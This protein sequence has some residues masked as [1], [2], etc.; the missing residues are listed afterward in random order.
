MNM[1]PFEL[2]AL[3]GSVVM[4]LWNIPLIIKIRR[5]RSA[6]DLSLSWLWGV[7]ACIA[8]MLPWGIITTSI[9]L[10]AFSI[11]NFALF[12]CVVF[13]VMKYRKRKNNAS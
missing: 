3:I 7:W 9:V 6:D 11:V 2:L 1:H 8:V 5:R 13:I 12:S 4:P 10:K